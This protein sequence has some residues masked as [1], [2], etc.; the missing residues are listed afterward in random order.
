[1]DGLKS[2]ADELK[3]KQNLIKNKEDSRKVYDEL[4]HKYVSRLFWEDLERPI[5]KYAP[6]HTVNDTAYFNYLIRR[7]LLKTTQGTATTTT[8]PATDKPVVKN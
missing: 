7:G 5:S 8:L 2:I 3:K 6:E 1:M 4:C